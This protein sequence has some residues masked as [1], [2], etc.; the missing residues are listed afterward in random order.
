MGLETV[1]EEIIRHAK[2]QETALMAEASKETN[3]IMRETE[4]KIEEIKEKSEVE[5]KKIID[6]IK[7]QELASADMENKK[8]LL[9][10]KKQVIEDVFIEAKKRL[11]KLESKKREIYIKKIIEK[12]KKDIEV[13]HIYC[14]KSDIKFLKDLN[15]GAVNIIGGLIAE[16]KE[17]TIRVDNSFETMLE[18][19]K[20]K[21]LQNI[22][23]ILFG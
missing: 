16:N 6:T 17:K 23:K 7:R 18:S 14:N 15:A 2:G 9:Q 5:T 1:K 22:N 19:I 11:E 3:R 4:K 21:E 10:A 8:V 13:M 12:T 20:E